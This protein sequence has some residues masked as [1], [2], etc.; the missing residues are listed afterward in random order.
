[1]LAQQ[2]GGYARSSR[3]GAVCDRNASTARRAT[4]FSYPPLRALADTPDMTLAEVSPACSYEASD[5]SSVAVI[6]DGTCGF[7]ASNHHLP[8]PGPFEDPSFVRQNTEA[9]GVRCASVS[10]VGPVEIAIWVS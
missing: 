5:T 7:V 8:E 6:S 9:T 4:V 2:L 10:E 1:V 3:E